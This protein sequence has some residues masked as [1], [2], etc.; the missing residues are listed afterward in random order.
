M[1]GD[2]SASLFHTFPRMAITLKDVNV[3]DSLWKDHEHDLLKADRIFATLNMLSLLTGK[4]RI[5]RILLEGATINLYTDSNG[6]SNTSIF[7]KHPETTPKTSG[8]PPYYPI[9][10]IKESK[11]IM[12]KADK[13]KL[14]RFDIQKLLARVSFPED[15][16]T[17]HLNVLLS[18]FSHGLGFNQANG[19]F[20]LDKPI[21]GNFPIE[22]NTRTKIMQFENI[23]LAVDDQ[24]IRFTGKFMLAE[25]PTP[26]TLSVTT[27]NLP[28]KKAASFV[29]QNIRRKLDQYDID[30]PITSLY[31]VLDNSDPNFTTPLIHLTLHVKDRNITTPVA[32]FEAAGFTGSY[33]N[34][35]IKG[36]GHGDDNSVLRFSSFYGLWQGMHMHADSISIYDLVHP[37][38][39]CH[40][41]TRI[42]LVNANNLLDDKTLEF[43]GGHARID[44]LYRGS[45]DST[46]IQRD[47]VGSILL[48]T[49]SLN[50]LPRNFSM[51]DCNG[52]I[53]FNHQDM[54]IDDLHANTGSSDLFMNGGVKS[55]FSII[56]KN[57]PILSL[58]WNIQSAKIN[59][60]DFN[61]FLKK[62]T[63]QV[64]K[65]KTESALRGNHFK[66]YQPARIL[67][68][69]INTAV[70]KARVQKILC[71][72]SESG[73]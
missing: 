31:C 64:V 73:G 11:F 57:A 67:Q 19:A 47:I 54:Y 63:T 15:N 7:K 41:N 70:K 44:L 14:F 1:V 25:V 2:I 21:T 60:A 30:Q 37:R 55:L 20:V 22:F 17:L 24:P 36:M 27:E 26:F 59:L 28:Y 68:H 16:G 66:N 46:I 13:H 33:T 58:N 32:S 56:D 43:T 40:L 61:G 48:D 72:Q 29:S 5:E 49:A 10:E 23:L 9:V 62:R 12:E 50:Y 71:D 3:H 65:K 39:V 35:V 53:R 45:L 6:Y 69:A 8:P 52:I 42:S 4:L 18:V 34:E 38:V 51:T